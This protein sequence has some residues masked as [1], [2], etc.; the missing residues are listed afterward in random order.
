MEASAKGCEVIVS[1]KLRGQRAKAMKFGDGYM[2]KTG[3]AGQ[4]Y[5]DVA[6]RHVAMRQ[7]MIGIKVSI[8]LPH[9]PEGRNGPK[10]P[11]D[12]VVTILEPKEEPSPESILQA[13]QASE[14]AAAAAQAQAQMQL[15]AQQQQQMA[16]DTGAAAALPPAELDPNMSAGY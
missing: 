9:D 13:Q 16:A 12:D 14:A 2:I 5:T 1:G 15:L 6:V 7:G 3:H 8:M 4:V 10:I 11:L